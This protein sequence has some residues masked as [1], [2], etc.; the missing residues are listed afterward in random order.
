MPVLC[1]VTDKEKNNG[2][3]VFR[4]SWEPRI[5]LEYYSK[6]PYAGQGLWIWLL[7]FNKNLH[8]KF[9]NYDIIFT[10]FIY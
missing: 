9:F 7:S 8:G 2:F 6:G 10:D 5:N 1:I 3:I 4:D